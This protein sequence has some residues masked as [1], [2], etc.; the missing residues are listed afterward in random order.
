MGTVGQ[1]FIS[2]VVQIIKQ[3]QCWNF[4]K[5]VFKLLVFP[6]ELEVTVKWKMLKLQDIFGIEV[7]TKG[8]L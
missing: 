1:L 7:W 6:G 4:L 8:V 3:H 2:Y 5:V